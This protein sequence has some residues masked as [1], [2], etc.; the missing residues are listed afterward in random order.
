[1]NTMTNAFRAARIHPGMFRKSKGQS[2]TPMN[3]TQPVV[4]SKQRSI[5][6][7]LVSAVKKMQKISHFVHTPDGKQAVTHGG[8]VWPVGNGNNGFYQAV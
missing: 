5:N 4:E 7:R 1:M 6:G 3:H 2:F 8:D